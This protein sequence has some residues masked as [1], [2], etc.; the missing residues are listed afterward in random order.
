MDKKY[1]FL[2][3]S[4]TGGGSE[5]VMS[6][7]ASEFADM[8]HDTS[9]LLLREKNQTT[10]KTSNKLKCYQLRYGTKNKLIIFMKRFKQV[11]KY[12]KEIDPDVVISFMWDINIFTILVTLG[13]NK[14]VIISERNCPYKQKNTLKNFGEKYIYPLADKIVFQTEE[15]KQYYRNSVQ[16]RG[17]VIPNPVNSQLPYRFNGCR[18]KKIIAAGRLTNQKNF[19]MLIKAFKKF[20]YDYPDYI[21]EIYGKGE[22]EIE[23]KE[24]VKNMGIEN[25]VIFQ[26]YTDDLYNKMINAE[27]YVSSSDFEGISN[28][29]IEA[30]AMGVPSICT[31][32]P[33]G[34][35]AMMINSGVNGILIPV[36]DINALYESMCKIASDE[37]FSKKLS[38]EATKIREDYSIKKIY[39]MWK[40]L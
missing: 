12:I 24:L 25:S 8:G 13:L 11:R 1:M 2:N 28:S 18:E 40:K 23:L 37:K 22:L 21:L 38:I 6:I 16:K 19:P 3:S 39:E 15:V 9:M 35:A 30:L 17:V 36:G 20:I 7:I 14:K 4:L 33:V 34:G 29:M 10:Y 26:G 5:R 27:M 32:C 31:D